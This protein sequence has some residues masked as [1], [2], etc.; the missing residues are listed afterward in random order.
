M[1]S[2]LQLVVLLAL[3]GCAVTRDHVLVSTGTVLGFEVAQSQTT[4][5]YQTKLGY[6]RSE[7]VI[8]PTNNI[9]VISELQWHALF[10]TGGLS[11]RIAIGKTACENSFP[12][13]SKGLDGKIDPQVL[14]TVG[15][16]LRTKQ[17]TTN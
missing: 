12:T 17:G 9:D 3:T 4:G 15:Q 1:K 6:A 2:L 14:S 7:L 13:F 5:L 10:S 16:I 8:A 11:Q